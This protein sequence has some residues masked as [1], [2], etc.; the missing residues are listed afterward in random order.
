[1]SKSHKTDLTIEAASPR[2]VSDIRS[3]LKSFQSTNYGTF[4][5]ERIS[6]NNS[7]DPHQE[8]NLQKMMGNKRFEEL[9]E[10]VLKQ[11]EEVD[12]TQQKINKL[13]KF[14]RGISIG[15]YDRLEE[16]VLKTKSEIKQNPNSTARY[17][18]AK[19][20]QVQNKAKTQ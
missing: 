12:I 4:S 2:G 14:L 9:Q 8:I 10:M 17:S 16:E 19:P 7:Q 18:K 15:D 20:L 3:P 1:M 6:V 13:P 5:D 11:Q